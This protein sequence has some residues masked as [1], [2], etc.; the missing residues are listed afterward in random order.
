[1]AAVLCWYT[2]LS[3]LLSTQ[4][5]FWGGRGITVDHIDYNPLN[6]RLDNLRAVPQSVNKNRFV[7]PVSAK[8]IAQ[9]GSDHQIIKLFANSHGAAAH[10]LL[11]NQTH[12]GNPESISEY[13][14]KIANLNERTGT[15]KHKAYGYF[16]R[17]EIEGSHLDLDG[18]SWRT[19]EVA[20]VKA[21]ISNFGR[22]KSVR[23]SAPSFGTL[24]QAGYRYAEIGGKRHR[25]HQ[26]VALAFIGERPSQSHIVDHIDEDK[27]NNHFENLRWATLS[28]NSLNSS[29]KHFKPVILKNIKTGEMLYCDSTKDAAARVG[30]DITCISAVKN[31][32]LKSIRGYVAIKEKVL[33]V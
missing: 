21:I 5:L 33:E 12:A 7:T 14:R 19:L 3:W 22:V 18:E 16:W 27:Q 28:E 2:E 4:L 17:Y 25:I 24:T 15:N 20:G 1:M 23:R 10:V 8:K 9:I 26:L 31:G 32:R 30:T 13:I 29:Y 6:N 11:E